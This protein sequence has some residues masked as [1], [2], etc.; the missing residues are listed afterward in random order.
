MFIELCLVFGDSLDL[1]ISRRSA[2]VS[3]GGCVSHR[4]GSS[5]ICR[6]FTQR[7]DAAC[8]QHCQSCPK[9]A[10]SASCSITAPHDQV[11]LRPRS[12]ASKHFCS[13]AG[14]CRSQRLL[15]EFGG[16][17]R[18]GA[19]FRVICCVLYSMSF[20]ASCAHRERLA[21]KGSQCDKTLDLLNPWR[22][23]N[24]VRSRLVLTC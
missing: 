4:S 8:E 12:R 3:S 13:R 21:H 5:C 18:V 2:C 9:H 6:I 17:V 22:L 11:A 15:A 14:V 10:P 19:G 7:P 24:Y 23:F 20:Q 16:C 1:Q